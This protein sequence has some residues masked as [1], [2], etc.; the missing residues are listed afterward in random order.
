VLC[1]RFIGSIPRN[2]CAQDAERKRDTVGSEGGQTVVLAGRRSSRS[3]VASRRWSYKNLAHM[4]RHSTAVDK[5]RRRGRNGAE[6][7][8]GS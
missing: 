6:H 7:E 2:Q 8:C 1:S 3:Q 4:T 5:M